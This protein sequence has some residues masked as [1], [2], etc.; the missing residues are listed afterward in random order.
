M[1][2]L[3]DWETRLGETV[4]RWRTR[5]FR[6]DRDCAR[7]LADCVIAQTGEDPLEDL[8]GQYR[9]KRGAL[10]LLAE[11]PMAQRLDEKFPRVEPAFARRG[12][13]ALMQDSC[14]GLVLGGEAMAY[15]EDGRMTMFPRRDWQGV[16][17]VGHG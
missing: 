15:G 11:K 6:W 14:L 13:I 1:T 8:R 5:P 9:T 7:W 10:R 2:R 4:A 12:D 3:P 17:S 16:W